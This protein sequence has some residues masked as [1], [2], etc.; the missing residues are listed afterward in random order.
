MSEETTEAPEA[1]AEAPAPSAK[2]IRI[3][4]VRT[5]TA[6]T[7]KLRGCKSPEMGNVFPVDLSTGNMTKPFD[8]ACTSCLTKM[9][10]EGKWV[11]K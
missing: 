11:I 9:Q 8:L 3:G 2:R 5:F 10:D 4:P 6:C 1:G 7:V